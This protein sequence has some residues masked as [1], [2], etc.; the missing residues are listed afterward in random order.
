MTQHIPPSRSFLLRLLVTAGIAS[1]YAGGSI[2]RADDRTMSFNSEIVAVPAPGEVTIDGD[3]N[4]WDL[5]AGV[6]SYNNPTIVDRYSVWTHMMWDKNGIYMLAR[7]HDLTPMQNAARGKDFQ[8]SWRADAYQARV[9]LDD[10]EPEEHQIHVNMFYSTQEGKPYMIAKHGGFKDKAP[11][12]DTGPNR[13]DLLERFGP[14]LCAKGGKIAFRKW[15]DNKGYNMEVFWPWSYLRLNG[16]PLQAGEHFT[17]GI[18]AMWGNG[19]GSS[20]VHRLADGI[21]NETV[22]RIFMFRARKGWGHVVLSATGHLPI[23]QQQEALQQ[24]RFKRFFNYDTVGSVPIHYKLD[25]PREVTIAIDDADGKRVRNLFGQYPRKAGDITDYWDGLDDAGKPVAP[26]TYTATVV[27]HKPL[28]LK[29]Y[30]SLYNS[31][32]PPWYTDTGSKLWG[33][34]HGY[35]TSAS[36]RGDIRLLAFTGTEGC[37]GIMRIDATGKILWTDSNEFLDVTCDDTYAYGISRSSWQNRTMLMRYRLTDGQIMPFD[38]ADKSP[39]VTVVPGTDNVP[40]ATSIASAG[41]KLLVLIPGRS[42][43]VLTPATGAVESEIPAGSLVAVTERNE[44]FYG[45]TNTAEIVRLDAAGKPVATIA[46]TDGIKEPLRLAVRFDGQQFAISDAATNQVHLVDASGK[47]IASIGHAYNGHERPAGKFEVNDFVNPL[48]LDYDADGKLWVAE[49]SKFCKRVTRWSP[50]AKLEDQFWGSADYGGTLGFAVTDDSTR[51]I[52]HAVEFKLDPS[53]DVLHQKTKEQPL[54]YHP[55]LKDERGYVYRVNGHDYAVGSPGTGKSTHISIFKRGD[56][57]VFHTCARIDLARQVMEKGKRVAYPGR[58]WVDLNGD[59]KESPDE[60]TE[61]MSITGMYWANG[62]IRPDLTILTTDNLKFTPKGFTK[63]GVPTYDFAHPEPLPNPLPAKDLQGTVT[64]PVMDMAG[65]VSTGISYHTADGR[66]GRYPNPYGR[67]DAPAAKRGLLIAPFRTNGVVENVPGVGSV[68]AIG[69]DRG[70]WFVMSLDGLYLSNIL[71]DSKGDITPDET[72]VG[73]ESFGGLFWRDEQGRVLIQVGGASYR[74]LEVQGLETVRK[75]QLPLTVSADQITQGAQLASAA[76]AAAG[77]EPDSLIISK[78]NQLPADP[79]QP[80]ANS[81]AP[82]ID[83][84]TA[85]KVVEAGDPSRWWRGAL[86]HDGKNLALMYQVADTSPWKNGSGSFTHAFIGGDSVDLQLNIP[87]RGPVRILTAP[88]GGKNTVI[89]WQQKAKEPINATTYM[90]ANNKANA[91]HFDVVKRLDDAK[92]KTAVGMSGYSVLVT[93]PLADL[94]IDASK[95]LDL[96]GLMGVVF[97]DPSG[98]NRM[99]R[100]YWHSKATDLVSDVPSESALTPNQ[101]GPI[102]LSN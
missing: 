66:V 69:G 77:S 93:I 50:E 62:W 78:V 92:V 65:N 49:A 43:F 96:T 25:E 61:N 48:G 21:Q 9:I 42:L 13:P 41:G 8:Q 27:D 84:A 46:K 83:G 2:A 38:D 53:P 70:E 36:T 39:A 90:V 45:L 89:Y 88:V 40:D 94:G 87:G 3:T 1:L 57:G 60:V 51:F 19:D 76:K 99:A 58:G 102:H 54:I 17:Y 20:L 15:D 91:K 82:F 71:Q 28:S 98:T 31:A 95:P 7:Y 24:D 100:L 67:H 23:T 55:D 81:T 56:D 97:S 34:N 22:N 101:W 29:L 10:G 14:D 75:Q 68:T 79:V 33:S 85:F 12:D 32:T 37:S 11:Y 18:E 74:L 30:N 5:S 86:A 59:G 26:G 35:P 73:Q 4:D 52:A 64:T 80:D 6:W 16:Q 44:T 47:L 72:F 63:D